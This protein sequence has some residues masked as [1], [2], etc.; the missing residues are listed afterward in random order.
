M[1]CVALEEESGFFESVLSRYV[2]TSQKEEVLRL[3]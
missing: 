1:M 3:F 2:E